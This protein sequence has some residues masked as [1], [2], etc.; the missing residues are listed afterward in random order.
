MATA[1]SNV[2]IVAHKRKSSIVSE[3]S[4]T[5]EDATATWHAFVGEGARDV[6]KGRVS[7]AALTGE[8]DSAP[9][10]IRLRA[11]TGPMFRMFTLRCLTKRG[12]RWP[13]TT[14]P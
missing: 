8:E 12:N 4:L 1:E 5:M 11:A 9:I 3:H 13:T 2:D 6:S 14:F 7:F 10:L